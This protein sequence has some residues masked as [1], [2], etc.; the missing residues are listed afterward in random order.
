MP[1]SNKDLS[2]SVNQVN[3]LIMENKLED[4]AELLENT[5]KDHPTRLELYSIL[6]D[7]Y[8][9]L[10]RMKIPKDWV[11]NALK[12]DPSLS[13]SFLDLSSRL[14]EKNDLKECDKLLETLV[15]S[16]P[17][18]HEIWNDLGAVRYTLNDLVTSER[19]FNQAL[20]LKPGYGE[21]I[22]NLTALYMATNRPQLAV[23]TAMTSLK[24]SDEISPD[25]MREMGRLI[26]KVAP[27]EADE[28]FGKAENSNNKRP[29]KGAML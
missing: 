7:L 22:T 6:C 13:E 16:D 14:Y 11:L 9:S 15:W 4:A 5:L 12:S 28:L 23:K 26:K 20:A 8:L 25:Q 19:A 18:N 27:A 29:E 21:A 1:S 24:K 2:D 3:A 10:G 17:D